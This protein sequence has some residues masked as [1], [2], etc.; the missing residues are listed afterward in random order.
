MRSFLLI[1]LYFVSS[2]AFASGGDVLLNLWLQA[3]L[4]VA[5][6]ISL[7]A[8]KQRF[9]RRLVIFSAYCLG[10]LIAFLLVGN[11]PYS[12][13]R[14]TVDI[15]SIIMPLVFWIFSYVLIKKYCKPN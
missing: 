11:L 3:L 6:L 13:N 2:N 15:V 5:V 12:A 14:L 9:L 7:I 10:H 1:T 8:L 4:L